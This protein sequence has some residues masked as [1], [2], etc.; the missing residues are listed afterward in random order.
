MASI[1]SELSGGGIKTFEVN[2]LFGTPLKSEAPPCT[3]A[4][5][6]GGG[7]LTHRAGYTAGQRGNLSVTISNVEPGVTLNLSYVS[8]PPQ[9]L[10]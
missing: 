7:N 5:K 2:F 9:K 8:K 1:I 3:C 4:P 10:I 6:H